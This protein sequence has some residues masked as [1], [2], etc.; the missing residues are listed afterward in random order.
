MPVFIHSS[1]YFFPSEASSWQAV[2]LSLLRIIFGTALEL[3]SEFAT[4]LTELPPDGKPSSVGKEPSIV[5]GQLWPLKWGAKVVIGNMPIKV[6]R[7]LLKYWQFQKGYP[8]KACVC[9]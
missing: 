9:V 5:W 2:M 8:V 4:H 7:I 3:P 6:M 1:E